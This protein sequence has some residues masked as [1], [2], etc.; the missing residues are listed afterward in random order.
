[1]LNSYWRT[2]SVMLA[3]AF[4]MLFTA[5]TDKESPVDFIV[6]NATIW[7]GN[8]EL[9]T[10]K[11]MAISGDTI[12]D[13]GADIDILTLKGP[14]TKLLDMEGA[15][16][17]PGFIDSH[18]HLMM[19]GNALL[20]VQLRDA[21]TPEEF[22]KRIGDYTATLQ[23]DNWV[24]EG[25]WDHTLWGGELPKK[26]WID[27]VTSENPVALYRLDGHMLLANSLALRLSGIDK[28]TPD[29]EGG[30]IVR[31]PDGTPTGIL[32]D[33]AMN[34]VLENISPM[35]TEEKESALKAAMN[36]LLSQ[37]VT[38]VHD[39][40]SLGTY[41]VAKKLK[42]DGK[43]GIRIY[44]INPLNYWNRRYDS[45]LESDQWLKT[46]GLKGFVDGSLGSHT[47]AF[48]AP[49]TDK[50]NDNG[51]LINSEEN[52]Y[53][54]IAMADKKD[55]QVLVHAIGDRAIHE[56]LDIFEKV[57]NEE[58]VKD[59]RFRM[60]HVQHITAKDVRRLSDLNII[61]SMQPYHAV[62]DGR[63][64]EKL[65][66]PERIKTTYA[67]RDLLNAGTV[68]AFGSDWPVAP[69]TPLEGI[70]AATTRRTLDGK[71]PDGWVPEQKI[72]VEEALLAYTK[73]GA[74][75][76]FEEAIKGTLEPGKLAD[77]VVLDK[78]ILGENPNQI[79][80]IKVLKTFVGGQK[81]YEATSN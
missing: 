81:V 45:S 67:F 25:N 35:T 36:Y 40:D 34:L 7:T 26:E 23:P 27:E 50:P 71:N 46:G 39:V 60:E 1:M 18:V 10:A 80:D 47:A 48:M 49:Y 30:Q 16:I 9:A 61:A 43:L 12:I 69:A 64:A 54:W 74:F 44:A 65:I 57:T 55:L 4:T 32:K 38:S 53:E 70:Y 17:T 22:T 3:L 66:G 20:S 33:N 5:C 8:S 42:E 72:T 31:Y 52:L 63:W 14:N 68:L 11:A 28:N 24:L 75:A 21:A 51:F 78:N 58:G 6:W 41:S 37:G 29:I 79:K 56:L 62:D 2:C 59:R 13:I 77:F 73:N 19:G 76:S 15:F